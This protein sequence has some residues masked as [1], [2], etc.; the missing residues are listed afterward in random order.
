MAVA[1]KPQ[2]KFKDGD[3]VKITEREAGNPDPKALTYYPFYA[4]LSGKII[5]AYDDGTIALDVDRGSLPEDIRLRHEASETNMREKWLGGLGEEERDR[6][7]EKHKNFSLRYTLLVSANDAELDDSPPPKIK[8]AKPVPQI[9]APAPAPVAEVE[10]VP[11]KT[12]AEIEAAEQAY[13]AS[14]QVK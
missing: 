5:K 3:R 10:T 14:K 13:L 7:S 9:A 2:L 1:V 11:R 8:R 12:A 6:L 4:N